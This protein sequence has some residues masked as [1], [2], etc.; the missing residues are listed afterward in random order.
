MRKM[1]WSRPLLSAGLL[2][3][4]LFALPAAAADAGTQV[5]V[6]LKPGQELPDAEKLVQALEASGGEHKVYVKAEK[7][8]EG[9]QLT[10]KLWGNTVPVADIPATLRQG[11]PVLAQADIQASMLDPAEQPPT[12]ERRELEGTPSADGTRRVIKKVEKKT[13]QEGEGK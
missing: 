7:R 10:L 5:T 3:L 12:L 8:P 1:M 11:F 9:Q 6:K 2:S 4:G 13:V